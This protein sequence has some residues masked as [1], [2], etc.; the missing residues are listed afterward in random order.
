MQRSHAVPDARYTV[1]RE[2]TAAGLPGLRYR[3]LVLYCIVVLSVLAGLLV[4]HISG[5]GQSEVSH[6]IGPADYAGRQPT[7]WEQYGWSIATIAIAFLLQGLLI[8]L[9]LFERQRRAIV[10]R[11]A[12]QRLSDARQMNRLI[13]LGEISAFIAHELRQPLGAML[14][15]TETLE[16]LLDGATPDIAEIKDIVADIRQDELRMIEII[17]SVRNMVRATPAPHRKT[18][19]NHCIHEALRLVSSRAAASQVVLRAELDND[20]PEIRADAVQLRQ[21]LLNIIV[22][23]LD[24]IIADRSP[25]K[26]IIARSTRCGR[27]LVEI[28]I[29]N[30]GP[31]IQPPVCRK[32]FDEYYT[33][34]PDG[35]GLG[36]AISRK[37]ILAHGG[38]IWVADHDDGGVG[39]HIHLPL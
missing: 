33:T 1:G 10:G 18:D 13:S 32:I 31:K 8:L 27:N 22:N 23:A 14:T 4:L 16:I 15:N 35:T 3:Y 26:E 29:V 36:L 38:R 11:E 5:F 6:A 30:Y 24:A 28:S 9:L 21:V 37:L 34:K 17:G 7:A 2:A 39:F 19:I 12:D 20:L 25:R